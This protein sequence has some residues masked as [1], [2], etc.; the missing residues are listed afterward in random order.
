M[1]LGDLLGGE[2]PERPMELVDDSGLPRPE[3]VNIILTNGIAVSADLRFRGIMPNGD[4]GYRVVA[5][6]DWD[7]DNVAVIEVDRWPRDV[8]LTLAVPDSV[9][10]ERC[11][12]IAHSIDWRVGGAS[13]FPRAIAR[14][15]GPIDKAPDTQFRIT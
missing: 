13:H 7:T 5:E 8:Q 4:R 14:D 15:H 1:D 11:R 6:I 9:P 2:M 10:D 12:Q 3:R